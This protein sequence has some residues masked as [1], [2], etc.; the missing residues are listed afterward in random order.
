ML[1]GPRSLAGSVELS[2]GDRASDWSCCGLV[3]P[4]R[5]G[6]GES[7]GGVRLWWLFGE[8]GGG[9]ERGGG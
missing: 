1:R 4:T 8:F 2:A 7:G 9:I 6:R 3:W 5:E